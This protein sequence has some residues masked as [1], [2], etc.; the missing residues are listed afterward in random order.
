MDLNK[1]FKLLQTAIV[2]IIRRTIIN[3]ANNDI[4]LVGSECSRLWHGTI[5]N[6][7]SDIVSIIID[8]TV[9]CKRSMTI[10]AT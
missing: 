2:S 5:N 3:P 6:L 9:C 10:G 1:E 4:L 7:T 8:S